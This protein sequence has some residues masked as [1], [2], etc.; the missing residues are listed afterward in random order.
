MRLPQPLVVRSLLLGVLL[1]LVQGLAGS[2]APPA[3]AP[4]ARPHYAITELAPPDADKPD[5]PD[6]L[7]NPNYPDGQ[8]R[9]SAV[10]L[11]DR[12][13]VVVSWHG[14]KGNG[15]FIWEKGKKPQPLG[16]LPDTNFLRANAINN[17][18]QVVGSLWRVNDPS[19][20]WTRACIWERGVPR[21]LGTTL[22][23]RSFAYDINN[24]GKVYLASYAMASGRYGPPKNVLE[25]AAFLWTADKGLQ[26]LPA[27]LDGVRAVLNDRG[28]IAFHDDLTPDE[29]K[30]SFPGLDRD[31]LPT[32]REPIGA[33]M[34]SAGTL[35]RL[36]VGRS[37]YTRVYDINN[38][39]DVLVN[40]LLLGKRTQYG[41]RYESTGFYLWRDGQATLVIPNASSGIPGYVVSNGP[42]LNEAGDVVATLI[43][44]REQDR[45][46]SGEQ[47]DSWDQGYTAVLYRG[48]TLHYLSDCIPRDSGWRLICCAAI[49]NRGQIVGMGKYQGKQRAFL[50][51]P[52]PPL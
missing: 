3:T 18:G 37:W 47:R 19:A 32:G 6:I 22:G 11:N 40:G 12:G 23:E 35:R 46:K 2:D 27:R 44:K 26:R 15:S 4:P 38:R 16:Y 21:D 33:F 48:G 42:S 51:T 10:A 25:S 8:N 13:Q 1:T 39:G 7:S 28:Q 41:T 45:P 36:L 34:Y 52:L 49:N 5:R 29:M 30:G 20:R 31:D 43:S 24:Q 50:L 17:A 14:P 9:S